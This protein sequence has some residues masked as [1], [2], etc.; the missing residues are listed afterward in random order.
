MELPFAPLPLGLIDATSNVGRIVRVC[1]GII[2]TAET[3]S[4]SP[5]SNLAA[6]V[7]RIFMR[8]EGTTL[9]M[10]NSLTPT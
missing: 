8:L 7:V 1:P 9:P 10:P 4:K 3:D 6:V 2:E 5:A